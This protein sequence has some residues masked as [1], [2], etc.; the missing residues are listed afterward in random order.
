MRMALAS[1]AAAVVMFFWGFLF[2]GFLFQAAPV[3]KHSDV[4]EELLTSLSEALPETGV[5]FL[6]SGMGEDEEE[7]GSRHE[8]GPI[9]TVFMRHQGAPLM[10]PGVMLGG[11]VHM[12]LVTVLMA[13]LFQWVSPNLNSFG[14]RVGFVAFAG[15][16]GTLLA[17]FSTPIWFYQPWGF[18]IANSLYMIVAWTLTGA[19]F[20]LLLKPRGSDAL[21]TSD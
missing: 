12:L 20:A 5:Y 6:P 3:M 21:E 2:W 8:D 1:L 17:N 14:T 16:I 7:F 11:F 19:V 15:T 9:A 10:G 4:E 18:H 13:L